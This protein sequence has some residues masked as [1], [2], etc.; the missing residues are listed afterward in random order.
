M[1]DATLHS[2]VGD[3]MP[4]RPQRQV[5]V[6]ESDHNYSPKQTAGKLL[7]DGTMLELIREQGAPELSLLHF[8]GKKSSVDRRFKSKT[9]PSMSPPNFLLAF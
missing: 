8:D 7:E 4:V 2:I 9:G 1:R 6:W 3:R 5:T